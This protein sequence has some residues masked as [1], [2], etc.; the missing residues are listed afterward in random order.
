[1][2]QVTMS[3]RESESRAIGT[4]TAQEG[5]QPPCSLTLD[6]GWERSEQE[7]RPRRVATGPEGE[8]SRLNETL[9]DLGKGAGRIQ[10]HAKARSPKEQHSKCKCETLRN[11][12]PR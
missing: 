11:M 5:I 6:T 3:L 8:E 4:D 2:W 7:S 1:M 9:W 10:E 12:S